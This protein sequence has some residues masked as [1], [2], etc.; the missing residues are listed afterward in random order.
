[1]GSI[2]IYYFFVLTDIRHVFAKK[3]LFPEEYFISKVSINDFSVP[4]LGSSSWGVRLRKEA[5]GCW[6]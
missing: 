4:P 3:H 1:M 5:S 6:S 2:A